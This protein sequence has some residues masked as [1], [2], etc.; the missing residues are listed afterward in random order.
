MDCFCHIKKLGESLYGRRVFPEG[1]LRAAVI[2]P[3]EGDGWLESKGARRTSDSRGGDSGD[4][5]AKPQL[6]D[7]RIKLPIDP[8][9]SIPADLRDKLSVP[10]E[11]ILENL[12]SVDINVKGLAL[13]LLALRLTREIG[14]V[15][16]G[17][18][19]RSAKTQGA[20]VDLI[21][22]S[23]AIHYSRWLVQCKN[24]AYLRTNRCCQRSRNGSGPEGPSDM[25][26]NYWTNRSGS[27]S[28]CWGDRQVVGSAGRPH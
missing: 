6:L 20:E 25:H 14:L 4:V 28:I 27:P 9:N 5:K 19:E 10:L 3:L 21:A 24:T 7:L 22:D 1:A 8:T 12:S 11:E 26:G 16:A 17:F 15:P 18:R 2:D 23:L 13:E